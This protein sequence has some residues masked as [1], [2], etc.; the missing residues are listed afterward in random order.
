MVVEEE[1]LVKQQSQNISPSKELILLLIYYA[2]FSSPHF[3]SKDETRGYANLYF[4]SDFDF[5][6]TKKAKSDD[7]FT[8][9][10]IELCRKN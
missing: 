10:L 8:K 5:Y 9:L 1:E 3:S 4:K 2:S 6:F 7:N